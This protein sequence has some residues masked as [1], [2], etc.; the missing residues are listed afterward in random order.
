MVL[1]IV[2]LPYKFKARSLEVNSQVAVNAS[3]MTAGEM[4]GD[5]DGQDK[6]QENNPTVLGVWN[7]KRRQ[8]RAN[9]RLRDYFWG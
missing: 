7:G 5:V 1:L 6:L 8:R 4:D 2:M 3:P 9:T